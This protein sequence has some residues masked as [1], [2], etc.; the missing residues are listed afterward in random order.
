[1]FREA[2][3]V[4]PDAPLGYQLL[5]AYY[6]RQGEFDKTME[7]YQKRAELEPNNPEAWHTMGVFYYE[8][9]YRD[10]SVER[11]QALAYLA[12]GLEA[13]DKALALN[14][15][16]YEA[17]TYKAFLLGLQANRERNLAEQKR[18]LAEATEWRERALELEKKQQGTAS[19]N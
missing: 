18:L 10:A 11:E 17:V 2:I 16:Y 15:D 3:E 19:A 12:S 5:A 4:R 6:N 9:V 14:P 8:K 13:E 1:M 7:A